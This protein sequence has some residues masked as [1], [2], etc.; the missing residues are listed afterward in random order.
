MFVF[1]IILHTLDLDNK[2]SMVMGVFTSLLMFFLISSS[3]RARFVW[4]I[5]LILFK[6]F[7]WFN[8]EY[9]ALFST[10]LGITSRSH[11]NHCLRWNILLYSASYWMRR[12][13]IR[14][15]RAY[16]FLVLIN[17]WLII[18]VKSFAE[19]LMAFTK[20]LIASMFLCVYIIN[21]TSHIETGINFSTWIN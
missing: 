4:S 19:E 6:F 11:H 1:L 21:S 17:W 15:H 3:V 7:S 10:A 9:L 12:N 18:C 14:R 2:I 16:Y 20:R 5:N 8:N 13:D